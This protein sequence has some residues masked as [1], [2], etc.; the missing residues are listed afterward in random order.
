M[1]EAGLMF[2]CKCKSPII[3]KNRSKEAQETAPLRST[4]IISNRKD[5]QISSIKESIGTHSVKGEQIY[6]RWF[7][8]LGKGKMVSPSF[9]A[10]P[11]ADH[12]AKLGSIAEGRWYLWEM[13]WMQRHQIRI[14]GTKKGSTLP[15]F[16]IGKAPCNSQQRGWNPKSTR[17][18]SN[19]LSIRCCGS[20]RETLSPNN[21]ILEST[22][23][24]IALAE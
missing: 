15:D 16:A 5:D 11:W 13:R 20:F 17:D 6:F 3:G 14:R 2:H 4:K 24:R 12:F 10:E 9:V 19:F 23:Q 7:P 21:L 8:S 22:E 1:A 18:Y